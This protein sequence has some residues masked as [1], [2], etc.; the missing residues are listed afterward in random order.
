MSYNPIDFFEVLQKATEVV[1]SAG[2]FIRENRNKVSVEE[3]ESKSINSLV[4]YVDKNAEKILVEGLTPLIHDVGFITEEDTIEQENKSFTWIIDPLDGTTNFLH[5]IPVFSI[6]VALVKEEEAIL[7]I[8]YEVVGD[9]MFT[10]IKGHGSFLNGHPIYVSKAENVEEVVFATGFPYKKEN[11]TPAHFSALKNVL[12][13]TRGI[14]R[15]G[16]AAVDLCFVAC[17]RFGVYYETS[18][19]PWDVAAGGLIV[20]EAGGKVSTIQ[21]KNHW[22]SG[23][24][25][26]AYAP[27]LETGVNHLLVDFIS[28]QQA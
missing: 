24:S 13:N 17:G 7:G 27:G 21:K 3:I 6:S 18:L 28:P 11:L 4:S 19:N 9:E 25:I 16:T 22:L 8:V 1:Y 2:T 5:D 26:L 14:R 15:I 10:A 12:E 23:E 20:L